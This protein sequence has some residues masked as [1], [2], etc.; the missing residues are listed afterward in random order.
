MCIAWLLSEFG[1]GFSVSYKTAYMKTILKSSDKYPP[2]LPSVDN[3][4][5]VCYNQRDVNGIKLCKRSWDLP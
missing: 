1:G 4:C 5:A 3:G 2:P